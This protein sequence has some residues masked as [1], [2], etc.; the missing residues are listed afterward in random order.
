MATE[1][2]PETPVESFYNLA[3]GF[4]EEG[5]VSIVV[6]EDALAD[7]QLS[8]SV[9]HPD[10]ERE[11]EIRRAVSTGRTVRFDGRLFELC[12]EPESFE[13]ATRKRVTVYYDPPRTNPN[14]GPNPPVSLEEG[15]Q[16]IRTIIG[17]D[18][19][20]TDGGRDPNVQT[21]RPLDADD[22]VA[23]DPTS[24]GL[25]DEYD[26]AATH[27]M[28][29]FAE[30]LGYRTVGDWEFKYSEENYAFARQG[31][32]LWMGLKGDV[33]HLEREI[34]RSTTSEDA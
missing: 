6:Y 1:N 3:S 9:Y 32:Q 31:N 24:Y 15:I 17:D 20:V 27:L 13:V 21:E 34:N 14:Y 23:P 12:I 10:S 30:G 26:C 29:D 25:I 16:R 19:A 5:L 33:S 18:E 2:Q 7:G 28:M 4:I 22:D 11:Q 8:L